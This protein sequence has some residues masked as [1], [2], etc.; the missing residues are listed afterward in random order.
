MTG[1]G[2]RTASR[3]NS[4]PSVQSANSRTVPHGD[5]RLVVQTWFGTRLVMLVVAVWVMLSTHRGPGDVF[6]NWDVAH[7][8][9]IAANGYAEANS[10]A[11]FPGWPLLVRLAG[12]VGL[13]LL[14]V[15]IVLALL[16]SGFAAAALYRLGGAPAA[17]AWLLAPTAVFTMVPYSESV[18]CAAAFWAWERASARQW[19]AAAVLAAVAASVRVSGV[20]LIAALAVLALTQAGAPRERGRRLLWLALPVAVVA[21]YLGYL[22]AVTHSWTAWLDAQ[23]AGWARGFAWPWDSL[24]HTLAVLEP[25]AYANHPE[26]HWV[27][28]AE[29]ISM[30][31]GLL[32]TVV[33]LVRR[34]WGEATWVG[35]QVLAFGTSYWYM[36]VNRAVLLWF[37]L[38]ILVGGLLRGRGKMPVWRGAL[39]GVLVLVALAVQAVWAWLFFTGRWAS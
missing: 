20:F 15:G 4:R 16:A 9:G 35:L 18:F 19:G 1:A 3:R 24:R 8:L 33:C 21:A 12:S 22:F 13:P 26:W 25:G 37:P 29:I 28:L 31:V 38:W 5:A 30:A 27:F 34:R 39:I 36:S 2:S 23:T 11:F 14:A 10:I 7:Y 6:G 32:L 17:I